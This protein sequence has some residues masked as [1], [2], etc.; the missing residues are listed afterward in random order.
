MSQPYGSNSTNRTAALIAAVVSLSVI[1]LVLAL[2]YVFKGSEADNSDAGSNALRSASVF[3]SK[4]DNMATPIV[5]QP[6]AIPENNENQEDNSPGSNSGAGSGQS[7]QPSGTG[8]GGQPS[9]GGDEAFDPNK[10][11]PAE[12]PDFL[13][14]TARLINAK[15]TQ[16]HVDSWDHSRYYAGNDN[17]SDGFAVSVYNEFLTHYDTFREE[18]VVSFKATSPRNNHRYQMTCQ[19]H[20][21]FVAC[22]GGHNAVVYIV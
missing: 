6:A 4:S 1:V 2:L 10:P 20:E 22:T 18:G 16:V 15:P 11:P 13:P 5:S 9:G 7:N 14:S 8:Q 19:D 3:A 12:V 21:K 17:T